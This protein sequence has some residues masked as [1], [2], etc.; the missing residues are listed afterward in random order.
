M[1]QIRVA[2]LGG[3][4]R[5]V[6]IAE[7]LLTRG[8]QVAFFG[9]AASGT[10]RLAS[11]K[12]PED[13]VARANWIICPSPGLGDSDRVY[14]P[15]CPVPIML[16]AA[17]LTA[18]EAAT[19]GLILGRATPGVTSAAEA[20]GVAVFEMKD[21]R[22]LAVSNATAVAEALVALLIGK[23]RRVL[24]AHRLLV[25]GY[26]ATGAAFTDALLGLACA[27]RVT[28]RR[29][30][31]LER[32]RQRGAQPVAYS[33][34]VQAMTES[35]IVVNTVPSTDAIPPSA[36]PQLRDALVVDIASPP[37]GT[38]HAAAGISGVDLT[39]ARGLA[40]ARAPLSVGDAQLRFITDAI[41]G[42]APGTHT[43]SASPA[44]SGT[45]MRADRAGTTERA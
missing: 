27:V 36:F 38:D 32:A 42:S 30:E 6:Y 28:A 44:A 1:S 14:A 12:S 16:N 39:W 22:A 31:H 9:A 33:A 35:D 2:V 41:R 17:L 7:Q 5:E 19:G 43:A 3:D 21:D 20:A 26:G 45:G 8:Y 15:D 29:A 4:A 18:S 40:G 13:A 24:P 11:A 10:S 23:T 25:I 37:G 34:R